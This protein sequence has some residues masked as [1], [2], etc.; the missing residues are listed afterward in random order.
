MGHG[1]S[2][3]QIAKYTIA[4][5]LRKEF[6]ARIPMDPTNFTKTY[7]DYV[8]GANTNIVTALPQMRNVYTYPVAQE[9]EIPFC[10]VQDSSISFPD[11]EQQTEEQTPN[12]EIGIL[13]LNFDLAILDRCLELYADIIRDVFKQYEDSLRTKLLCKKIKISDNQFGITG[14]TKNG[15]IR[16]IF[17]FLNIRTQE[18]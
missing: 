18:Y 17:I 14:E 10:V 7:F 5:L 15:F 2:K 11:D 13:H 8:A 4:S 6:A 9:S 1:M 12:L 16:P 3:I